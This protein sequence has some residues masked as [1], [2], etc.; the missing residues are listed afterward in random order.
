MN[1]DII[2]VGKV[3]E[4]YYKLGIAEYL[5]RLT[6]YAKVQIL[7]VEDE[8]T[9]ENMSETERA[10]VLDKEAERIL[11]HIKPDRK[12]WVLAI[13]GK[14]VTSIDIADLLEDYA[15]Y[16]H[17]KLSIVIGG[18]LGLQEALKN[19]A[20]AS[21]SFGRITMPHQMVRL[22]LVEQIYR[23]FRIIN[24]EPYHK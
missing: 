15:I 13:E 17:S 3:K 24:H 1:I 6:R 9:A 22:V 11:S 10:H 20:D 21:L 12:L 18:S 16:G 4:K 7:E 5:K 19:R 23:A 2:V 14:L 8:A